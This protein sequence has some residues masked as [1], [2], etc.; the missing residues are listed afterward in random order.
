VA[1]P[2][3]RKDRREVVLM[4][5]SIFCHYGVPAVWHTDNG[6]EFTNALANELMESLQVDVRQVGAGEDKGP[7]G[8]RSAT[9][10]HHH[11][12]PP[13]RMGAVLCQHGGQHGIS[14]RSAAT[15]GQ[16]V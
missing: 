9:Q 7:E 13:H 6:T 8:Q 10:E 15:I 14:L 1:E 3:Y 16:V 12:S 2:L 4:I 5:W 11:G